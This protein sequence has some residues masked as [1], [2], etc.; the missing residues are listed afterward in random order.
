M[1]SHWCAGGRRTARPARKTVTARLLAFNDAPVWRIGDEIVTGFMPDQYRFPEIPENLHERPTLI[2]KLE[3][4]GTRDH[5]IETSY[6]AGNMTWNADYVLTV[7]T[8]RSACGSGW[9]GHRLEHERRDLSQRQ[10]AARCR[11][12]ASC[13]G[14][15]GGCAAGNGEGGTRNGRQ[16]AGI[17]ARGVLRIPP[18]LAGTPHDAGRERDEADL[19]AWRDRTC[20]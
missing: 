13:R 17:H 16:P 1:T 7:G 2:W 20:R 6:L 12:P 14:G 3:N 4:G 9:L 5:R 11:R 10:T 15:N 8:R 19:A 18:L